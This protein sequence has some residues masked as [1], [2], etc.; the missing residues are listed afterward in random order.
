MG[1]FRWLML[2]A[3]APGALA[4]VFLLAAVVGASE[5]VPRVIEGCVTQGALISRDGYRIRVR[6]A[7]NR[8]MDLTRYEGMQVRFEGSLLPGDL[9]FVR[10][11]PTVLGPCGNIR[12][13]PQ[14]R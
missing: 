13:R 7:G 1:R 8:P 4:G 11:A 9:Y 5:P 14:A 12:R 2:A 3:V 6:W 10:A